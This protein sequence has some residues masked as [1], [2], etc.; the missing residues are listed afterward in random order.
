[1]LTRLFQ[2]P[3]ILNLF[4]CP[5]GL[6]NTVVGFDG[7]RFHVYFPFT[8]ERVVGVDMKF[9]TAQYTVGTLCK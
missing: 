4:S 9:G 5:L 2:N 8:V 3:A 1:M 6:Q 7:S